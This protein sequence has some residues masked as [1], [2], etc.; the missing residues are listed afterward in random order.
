MIFFPRY[1]AD[2]EFLLEKLTPAQTG[3]AM[4]ACLVNARNLPGDG[5]SA[6]VELARRVP[7]YSVT[8]PDFEGVVGTLT[9][10]LEEL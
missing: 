6:T 2:A 5:F 8:Y 9:G 4:M 3:M 10:L 1:R 7:A